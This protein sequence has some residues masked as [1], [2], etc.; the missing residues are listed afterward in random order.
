M[1]NTKVLITGASGGLGIYVMK[2]LIE[3]GCFLHAAVGSLSGL[4]ALDQQFPGMSGKQ[5]TAAV[6]D[7]TTA[8]GVKDF[9]S[10]HEDFGALVHLAGGFRPGISLGETSDSDFDFL[11]NLNARSTFLLLKAILPQMISR[12]QGSI[13]TIGA[14]AVLHP[15]PGNGAYTASK[16]ALVALTLNAAEEGRK[17]QVRA[18][19]IV[20]AV[21]GTPAAKLGIDEKEGAKWTPPEDIA[22]L[23]SFLVADASRGITG[24]L[25]PMYHGIPA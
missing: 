21:I 10:G 14:R 4:A 3:E 11:M 25:F 12:G 13:V 19:C 20:P 1:T 8:S 24:T 9:F 23:V 17:H 15:A 16:S 6:S 7:I 18:N 22:D 2:R 5:F